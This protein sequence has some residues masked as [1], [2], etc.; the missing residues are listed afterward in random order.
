MSSAH[1]TMLIGPFMHSLLFLDDLLKLIICTS[2]DCTL[3]STKTQWSSSELKFYYL[4]I[5]TN[6]AFHWDLNC[7]KNSS[8]FSWAVT[9][10]DA[11]FVLPGYCKTNIMKQGQ[12]YLLQPWSDYNVSGFQGWNSEITY[13][14]L[15]AFTAEGVYFAHCSNIICCPCSDIFSWHHL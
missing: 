11:G 15:S 12:P 10:D 14:L 1:Q 13:W 8:I 2:F 4:L 9:M 6:I 5:F 7:D 3:S